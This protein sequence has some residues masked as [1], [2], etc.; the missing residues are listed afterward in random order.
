MYLNRFFGLPNYESP[1]NT[2]AEIDLE[3]AEHIIGLTVT[4]NIGLWAHSI[5]LPSYHGTLLTTTCEKSVDTTTFSKS[6]KQVV[7]SMV[8]LYWPCTMLACSFVAH[9]LRKDSSFVPAVILRFLLF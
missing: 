1:V 2:L 8:G 4:D 5:V 7:V 6:K 9:Y 3:I